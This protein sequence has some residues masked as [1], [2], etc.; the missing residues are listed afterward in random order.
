MTYE[1]ALKLKE[2]GWPQ[3]K[4]T[5]GRVVYDSTGV[6]Y[7]C[8]QQEICDHECTNCPAHTEKANWAIEPTLEELIEAC[9]DDFEMVRKVFEHDEIGSGKFLYWFAECTNEKGICTEGPTPIEAVANL[10]LVLNEKKDAG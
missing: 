1:L 8:H 9:G 3:D 6:G 10:W 2:T 5:E 4:P 7:V